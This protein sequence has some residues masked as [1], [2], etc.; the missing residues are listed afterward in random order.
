MDNGSILEEHEPVSENETYWFHCGRCGRLHQAEVDLS[1]D[2]RCPHCG[3]HPAPDLESVSQGRSSPSPQLERVTLPQPAMARRHRERRSGVIWKVLLAWL[4]LI[5]LIYLAGKMFWQGDQVGSSD[6]PRQ[7]SPADQRFLPN[8]EDRELL[9]LALPDCKR[10]LVAFLSLEGVAARLPLVLSHPDIAE[11]MKNYYMSNPSLETNPEGI[12]LKDKTIF[13]LADGQAVILTLWETAGGA[14]FDAAFRMDAGSWVLDWEH[15]VRYSDLT[16]SQFL[17]GSGDDDT[18]EFRL[19]ARKRNLSD[20]DPPDGIGVVLYAPMR[21][22][23]MEPGYRAQM[24]GLTVSEPPGSLLKA[25]FEMVQRNESVFGAGFLDINPRD[26]IRVRVKVQRV[27][28]D[29]GFKYRIVE[30]LACHW[31]STDETGVVFE[32]E[33]G[34]DDSETGEEAG[35]P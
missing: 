10:I 35:E 11:R 2:R 18:A 31:Y 5:G 4:I 13:H 21:R 1:G 20:D 34:T 6:R 24:M 28:G 12:K 14:L 3:H 33:A 25:A 30:M 22:Y 8:D 15:F 27:S 16:W 29:G 7:K 19:L 32:Q 17:A 9:E 26:M 23:L